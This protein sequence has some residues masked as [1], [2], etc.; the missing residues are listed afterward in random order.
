MPT[1]ETSIQSKA[2]TVV[3]ARRV[4]GD[5]LLPPPDYTFNPPILL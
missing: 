3:F 4:M 2:V 5:T 1:A